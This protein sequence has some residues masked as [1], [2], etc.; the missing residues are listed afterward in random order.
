MRR[1][2]RH[3][4][5]PRQ[6]PR[7]YRRRRT[8]V[9]F[10]EQTLPP[11][12]L[13]MRY[14]GR[15]PPPPPPGAGSKVRAAAPR[16][17]GGVGARIT[18]I[19]SPPRWPRSRG[20]SSHQNSAPRHEPVNPPERRVVCDRP[21]RPHGGGGLIAASVCLLLLSIRGA[22]SPRRRRCAPSESVSVRGG[23]GRAGPSPR[24]PAEKRAGRGDGRTG[25]R[26]PPPPSESAVVAAAAAAA[27]RRRCDNGS[28][29]CSS[30][31]NRA[32]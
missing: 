2:H 9:P 6:H 31:R 4:N 13:P 19:V 11:M 22:R 23:D 24:N 8:A 7:R 30:P 1:D 21:G 14:P 20:S 29:G 17:R 25:K 12:V 16:R 15:P 28:L 3:G 5:A 10:H 32:P 27:R 18:A 26:I